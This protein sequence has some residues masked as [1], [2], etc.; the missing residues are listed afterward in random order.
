MK[1]IVSHNPPR[2]VDDFLSIAFIKSEFPQSEIEYFPPQQ[3][4][5]EYV[6]NSSVCLIDVG[7]N[8]NPELS[9]FDHHQD[10]SLP[11]SLVM[12]LNYFKN[13]N[14]STNPIIKMIDMIDRMGMINV[15]NQ[16]GY[17]FSKDIDA[18]RK[19]ILLIDL[20]TNNNA[21][22]VIQTF[23]T[24]TENITD[25]NEFWKSFYEKLDKYR[26]LEESKE[27]IKQEE[28]QLQRKVEQA[29]KYDFNKLKVIY[30]YESFA[31]NHYKVFQQTGVDII[32]ER[33]AMNPDNTSII[34]NT[35]SPN[36]KYIDLS[37][38]FVIYPKVFLHNSG[39]IAVVDTHINN[40]DISHINHVLSQINKETFRRKIP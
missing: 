21:K 10:S 11:C 6:E 14:F 26:L 23:F 15:S 13:G 12:V 37:K 1:K 9:N 4:P 7:E 5:Q 22:K 3:I 18:Y 25:Y 38:I 35:H 20:N 34:K 19:P 24:L 8:F 40:F 16:T 29:K 17:R 32:V 36:A 31:P 39:F 30:S 28:I 27:I 2:H 33:N